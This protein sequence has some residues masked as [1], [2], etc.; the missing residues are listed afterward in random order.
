MAS[1][2][3]MC[4]LCWN[5]VPDNRTTSLFTK[6]SLERGWANR[7]T[8]LLELPVSQSDQLPPHICSK[9]MNRV[10]TLEKACVDLEDFKKSARA[11][12]QAQ[13]HQSLKRPKQTAGDSGVSPIGI[14]LI[15]W[16][17]YWHNRYMLA[18]SIMLA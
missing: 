15:C 1:K 14:S 8:A 11:C 9:C 18:L 3:L 13:A 12:M 6:K 10:I 17:N 4:R 7:I 2:L 16:H 5:Q